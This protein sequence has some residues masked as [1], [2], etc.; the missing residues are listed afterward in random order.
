MIKGI[1]I[2]NL[3]AYEVIYPAPVRDQIMRLVDIAAPPQTSK[4]ILEDPQLLESVEAVF[5]GWGCPVLNIDL[6][7]KAPI[8]KVIFYGAGSIKYFVTDAFWERNIQ[9]TSA[10][11]ANSVP[12]VEFCLAH[13]LLGLKTAWQQARVYRQKRAVDRL[14]VAGAYGSTVGLVSLGMIGRMMAERLKTFD[15][16]IIAYDPY[17]QE[18][19]GVTL[20]ALDDLFAQSDV[21][22]VHTP[23]LKETEGL[24]TGAHIA[25]MKPY[26]TLI[27]SSRGIILREA[28]MIAVLQQ[29][30]DLSAVLDVTY[31]EPPIPDSPL[32]ILPNVVLTPHI[33]GSVGRECQRMG[34]YMV[35]ELQRYLAGRPMKYALS[36]EQVEKM[37]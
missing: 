3:D 10:Y 18:Y 22:C 34:Q 23:W 29:R 28:E 33:A 13:I 37:A 11:A 8:L 5:S 1:F 36:R 17:V 16:N 32:F 31:P 24:I 2:L 35:D 15:V 30:H 12:V 14:P 21:V 9:V 25:S 26:S 4:S 20:C 27:N 6:L 19:P 7:E